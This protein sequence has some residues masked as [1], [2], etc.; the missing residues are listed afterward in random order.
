MSSL[1]S[2]HPLTALA[3]FALGGLGVCA[4]AGAAVTIGSDLS[5]APSSACTSAAGCTAANLSSGGGRAITAPS[6]GVVVRFRI[7]HGPTPPGA[8]YT[9][10]VL[11]GGFTG[12]LP[13]FA[14][15]AQAPPDRFDDF[16]S[17][18]IDAVATFDA[19]GRPRGV[20][21][22]SGQRIGVF[23]PGGVAFARPVAGSVLAE[24]DGDHAGGA[25][26]YTVHAGFE[27]LVNADIEPD[28]DGDGYGDESQDNC[29]TAANDQTSNPCGGRPQPGRGPAI[30]PADYVKP[31]IGRVVRRRRPVSNMLRKGVGVPI[32]CYRECSARGTLVMRRG[33]ARTVTVGRGH[34]SAS[35]GRFRLRLKLTRRGRR[36]LRPSRRDVRLRLRVR[37][38]DRWGSSFREQKLVATVPDTAR[39]DR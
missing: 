27:V 3:A 38:A 32:A 19:A 12:G 36:L 39:R 13:T 31:R 7:R 30:A 17:G 26:V 24:R 11:S 37:A 9:M 23:A 25:T 35:G 1:P 34:R 33:S 18:G 14:V 6:N 29:P 8:S 2:Y 10:K 5:G 22:S 4:E 20:P 16:V 21:I 28:A 15:A